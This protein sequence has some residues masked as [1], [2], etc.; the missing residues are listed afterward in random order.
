MKLTEISDRIDTKLNA[1]EVPIEVDEYEKSIYLTEAQKLIYK[2]LCD[3]FEVDGVVST[4]LQPFILE[5]ITAPTVATV[6]KPKMVPGAINI[7]V[8]NDIYRIVWEKAVLGSSD[9][10]YHLKE[11]KVIKTPIATIPYKLDN[12]FRMP[13]NK[14]I[15]RIIT[16]N[17]NSEL[18]ELIIPENT[19]LLQYSCKYLKDIKPIVLEALPEGLTVENESG[20][21]NTEFTDEVL[22]RIIDMA[23]LSIRRDKTVVM[24]KNV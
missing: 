15:L 22:D 18:F 7:I 19:E 17:T 9:I 14:E 12:P 23:V 1:F 20:P 3:E 16:G 4:Y 10:K 21:L 13:N 24:E 8:P 5:F 11:V 2:E 6:N